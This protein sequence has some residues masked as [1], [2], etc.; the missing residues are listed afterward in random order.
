MTEKVTDEM[1]MAFVDGE[2]DEGTRAA[3]ERA[4]A[5]DAALAA[6]AERFR[7]SRLLL[8]EAFGDARQEEVPPALIEAALGR[9]GNVVAWPGRMRVRV[10]LPLAASLLLV[11]GASGYLAGRAGTGGGDPLGRAAIEEAL[12]ATRSGE[13]RSIAFA[14]EAARFETLAT[15]RVPGGFCRSFDVTGS[16]SSLTGVGCDRG[17]GWTV[18]LTAERGSGGDTYAPASGAALQS[19]DAYLDALGVSDPLTADEEAGIQRRE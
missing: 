10:A 14:G 18:E 16:R 8:K 11:A 1:L 5:A 19:V 13:R 2:T 4:L 6:R 7:A 15:Y 3:I 12:S 17:G 9:R